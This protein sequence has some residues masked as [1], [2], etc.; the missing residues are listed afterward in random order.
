MIDKAVPVFRMMSATCVLTELAR[1]FTQFCA[2][3][4][5]SATIVKKRMRHFSEHNL[6]REEATL[7]ERL[8]Y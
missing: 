5:V 1:V 3:F 8:P 6:R 4:L 2:G 7:A